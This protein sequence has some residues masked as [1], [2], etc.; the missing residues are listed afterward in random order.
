MLDFG[1][2]EINPLILCISKTRLSLGPLVDKPFDRDGR[3]E[4]IKVN[5]Y[6]LPALLNTTKVFPLLAKFVL[7]TGRFK[8]LKTYANIKT[9]NSSENPKQ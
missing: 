5:S 6:S 2:L 1:L 3:E 9:G 7:E 4:E 8:F